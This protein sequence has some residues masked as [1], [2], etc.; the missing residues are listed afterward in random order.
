MFN[1]IAVGIE[2]QWITVIVIIFAIII[3]I[4]IVGVLV[5]IV[6]IIVDALLLSLYIHVWYTVAVVVW[7]DVGI[8]LI[9]LIIVDVT[10]IAWTTLVWVAIRS[11]IIVLYRW[12]IGCVDISIMRYVDI[13]II[14][15]VL[16]LPI[17]ITTIDLWIPTLLWYSAAIFILIFGV[18]INHLPLDLLAIDP[19][20][21]IQCIL[22]YVAAD[23]GLDVEQY[24]PQG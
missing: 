19:K 20:H 13:R 7:I 1:N 6:W 14:H 8:E 2:I 3:G 4:W 9:M 17:T 23:I 10:H 22:L 12:G 5:L 15:L 21:T 16:L 11:I 18:I 24:L